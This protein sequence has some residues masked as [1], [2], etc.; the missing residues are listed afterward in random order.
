MKGGANLSPLAPNG[1]E[2][3]GEGVRFLALSTKHLA[4]SSFYDA[5]GWEGVWRRAF[6][7]WRRL[8]TRLSRILPFP[9]SLTLRQCCLDKFVKVATMATWEDL[10]MSTVGIKDLKN[11]LT[12]Y[13]RRTKQGEEVIITER[14]KPIAMIQPIQAVAQAVSLDARLA[15]LAA[16]GLLTLPTRKPLKRMSLARVTGPPTSK[17]ILEDRR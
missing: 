13:L 9:F 1:G 10:A 12:H 11:R 17:T 8:F 6:S 16:R 15:Q 2:G 7:R 14:G 5:A 4:L 3:L